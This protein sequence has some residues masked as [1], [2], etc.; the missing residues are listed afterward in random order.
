MSLSFLAPILGSVAGG[1]FDMFGADKQNKQAAQLAQEN[2]DFQERMSSTAVQRRA[3]DMKAAGINPILAAGA[4]ASSPAG[5]VAPVTNTMTG[6]ASSAR[7]AAAAFAQNKQ[8]NMQTELLKAQ[9]LKVNQDTL[10]GQ[11]AHTAARANNII[12]E[13]LL[14][15]QTNY[16]DAAGGAG[17]LLTGG[18]TPLAITK[19]L[20]T[21]LKGLLSRGSLATRY[22]SRQKIK[23]LQKLKTKKSTNSQ[24]KVYKK[25]DKA[26]NF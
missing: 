4:S 6:P 10:V 20:G 5:S 12:N 26:Y 1:L 22:R 2:R 16:G 19:G 7:G 15:L 17:K 9:I 25:G 23:T 8:T 21:G 14:N 11:E 18:K 13:I 3:I 24:Y